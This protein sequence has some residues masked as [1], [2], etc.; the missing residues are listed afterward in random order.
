MTLSDGSTRVFSISDGLDGIT[1]ERVFK[2]TKTPEPPTIPVQTAEQKATDGFVPAGFTPDAVSTDGTWRYEWEWIRVGESGNWDD[3]Q[4][5][6]LRNDTYRTLDG[7]VTEWRL[8]EE[9]VT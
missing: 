3:W 6:A 5:P 8:G 7:S 1:D 9:Y 4:G 2:R